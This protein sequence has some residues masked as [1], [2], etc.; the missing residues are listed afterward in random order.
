MR[1]KTTW[2]QDALCRRAPRRCVQ[3]FQAS[4]QTAC[5]IQLA[6][7]NVESQG[8]SIC[9]IS[10]HRQLLPPV[11]AA[12]PPCSS[13]GFAARAPAAQRLLAQHARSA[14]AGAVGATPSLCSPSLATCSG[15]RTNFACENIADVG[16]LCNAQGEIMRRKETGCVT[17]SMFK[18]WSICCMHLIFLHCILVNCVMQPSVKQHKLSASA[19]GRR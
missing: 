17:G 15:T 13:C 16:T 6:L 4:R 9:Y 1:P 14:V 19:V 8:S 18:P 5:Y 10:R 12:L 11:R 3:K 2:P 7:L